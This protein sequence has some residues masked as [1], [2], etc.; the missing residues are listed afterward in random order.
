[1]KIWQVYDITIIVCE[2]IVTVGR[3][4]SVGADIVHLKNYYLMQKLA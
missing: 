1:M 4:S 3:M 2:Q